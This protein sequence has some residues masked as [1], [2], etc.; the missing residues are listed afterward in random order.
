MTLRPDVEALIQ[1]ALDDTLTPEER[2]RLDRLMTESVEARGRAAHLKE[3][4]DL[5]DSLGP[6]EPPATLAQDVLAQISHP[7]EQQTAG[8]RGHAEARPG[9]PLS[10]EPRGRVAPFPII[11]KPSL[12]PSA[13]TRGMAATKK[14]MLGLAA[15]AVLVLGVLTFMGYPPATGGTEA[16]IGGAQRAQSPQIEAK[17]VVLGDTSAQDVLQTATWD[18][19]VRDDTLR[20][21]LQDANFLA[22][23]HDAELLRALSDENILRALR[24][25]GLGK[26]LQ[27]QALVRSLSDAEMLKKLDDANLRVALMNKAFVDA[28]RN[29]DFRS[30]LARPDAAA[31]LARPAFQNALRDKGFARVLGDPR[32]GSAMANGL[33]SGCGWTC[34]SNSPV[35]DGARVN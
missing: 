33:N 25:P 8:A 10:A 35:V 14:I 24:D 32:F 21:L 18:Q 16:T 31:A 9:K 11:E 3:L 34:T 13:H 30:Q 1:G 5:L 26:K 7:A 29:A 4:T 2:E 27:D 12:R 6:A 15:A 19:I 20:T 28:L 22:R 17:D 23:L